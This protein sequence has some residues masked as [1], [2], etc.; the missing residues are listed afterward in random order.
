MFKGQI[1]GIFPGVLKNT[2]VVPYTDLVK[3]GMFEEVLKGGGKMSP[4]GEAAASPC[5]HVTEN[6]CFLFIIFPSKVW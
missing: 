4:P 3:M 5:I 2:G 6:T 1:V